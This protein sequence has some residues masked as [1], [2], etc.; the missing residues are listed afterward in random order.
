MKTKEQIEFAQEIIANLQDYVELAKVQ[1][2]L[3]V[4]NVDEQLES[5][6][7]FVQENVERL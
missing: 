6:T 2:K 5:I 3:K 7:Q 1:K 4:K